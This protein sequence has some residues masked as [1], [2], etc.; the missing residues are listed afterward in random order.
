MLGGEDRRLFLR[1]NSAAPGALRRSSEIPPA[2]RAAHAVAEGD[3]RNGVPAQMTGWTEDNYFERLMP[4]LRHELSR[5]RRECPNAA[6]LGLIIDGEASEWLSASF[7]GHI[8]QCPLCAELHRHLIDFEEQGIGPGENEW[9]NV[10]K[11]L[12]NWFELEF[13]AHTKGTE[14]G[15][16]AAVVGFPGKRR[17]WRFSWGWTWV[18]G[19]ALILLVG[20][21]VRLRH[22]LISGLLETAQVNPSQPQSSD[23]H[24]GEPPATGADSADQAAVQDKSNAVRRAPT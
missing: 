12:Q 10:E 17:G 14:E 24:A 8:A 4:T 20:G 16:K 11:R 18:A 22:G 9:K 15:A 13:P 5:R 2:E 19:L 3:G 23:S 7:R 6:D 1:R 21:S